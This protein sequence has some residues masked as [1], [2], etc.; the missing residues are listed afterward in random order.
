M[1]DISSVSVELP[2]VS[3]EILPDARQFRF[4]HTT[5]MELAQILA[6]I[7]QRVDE[8]KAAGDTRKLSDH[9]I[10]KAA[11]A[12]DAIRNMRRGISTP[13][14]KALTAIGKYL[15]INL[16][17]DPAAGK[18]TPGPDEMALLRDELKRT[19]AAQERATAALE[20]ALEQI[21]QSSAPTK[22]RRAK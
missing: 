11:G 7:D 19:T 20:R 21:E 12:N 17:A 13:K 16:L 15:G 10:S 6:L 9:A 4:G 18:L 8:L 1:P 3:T 22:H 2:H 5:A 14:A